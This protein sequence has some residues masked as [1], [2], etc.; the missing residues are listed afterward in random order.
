MRSLLTLFL[1][2]S[3]S[4]VVSAQTGSVTINDFAGADELVEQH[5]YF[6]KE[7]SQIPGWRIQIYSSASMSDAKNEKAKLLRTT[8][9]LHATIVFEAPNYKVRVGDYLNRFDAYR[10]LQ[11]IL[12]EYP[13]AFI[14]K[15]L[16]NTRNI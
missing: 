12:F 2:L 1:A 14:C 5:I 7:H 16:I 8:S 13:D 15:D 10:D 6:N 3:L 9:D 11:E 4:A